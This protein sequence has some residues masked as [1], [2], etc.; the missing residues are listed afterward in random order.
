MPTLPR[1]QGAVVSL[2]AKAYLKSGVKKGT[3][4]I[5]PAHSFASLLDLIFRTFW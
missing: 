3:G 5:A 2:R 1:I 4:V